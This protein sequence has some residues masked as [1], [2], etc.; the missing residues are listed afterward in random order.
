MIKTE[1]DKNVE[2]M[3]GKVKKEEEKVSYEKRKRR[4]NEKGDE[5]CG[6]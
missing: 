5:E 6:R 2:K 1:I 3:R 4:K